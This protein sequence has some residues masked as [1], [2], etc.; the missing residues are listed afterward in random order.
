MCQP[1]DAAGGSRAVARRGN[2]RP[3]GGRPYPTCPA[4]VGVYGH[5]GLGGVRR[6]AGRD[7]RL[8]PPSLAGAAAA[9][10]AGGCRG[11]RP[12]FAI[13]SLGRNKEP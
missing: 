3:A 1:H 11:H 7:G 13:L 5:G 9:V 8:A 2:H 4:R 10:G 12:T 6:R